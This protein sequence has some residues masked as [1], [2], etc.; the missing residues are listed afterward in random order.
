LAILS[1]NNPSPKNQKQPKTSSSKILIMLW[2]K[3]IHFYEPFSSSISKQSKPQTTKTTQT[4]LTQRNSNTSSSITK[5]KKPHPIP[6]N[7][8]ISEQIPLHPA[9]Q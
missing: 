1:A 7:I 6:T 3:K 8:Q 2:K 9:L 4:K 5:Q